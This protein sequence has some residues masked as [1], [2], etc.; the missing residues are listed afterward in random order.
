MEHPLTKDGQSFGVEGNAW[1][2][3]DAQGRAKAILELGWHYAPGKSLPMDDATVVFRRSIDGSR[4]W[5]D[6]VEPP[7]WKFTV[8]HNG[9][10]WLRGVSEGAMAR[11][12]HECHECRHSWARMQTLCFRRAGDT[13]GPRVDGSSPRV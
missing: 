7:Q 10:P 13:L 4:T 8:E 11:M 9:K 5:I 2:D 3:R 12:R 6:K 1:I